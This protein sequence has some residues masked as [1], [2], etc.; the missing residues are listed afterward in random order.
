MAPYNNAMKTD[1]SQCH[2]PCMCKASAIETRRLSQRYA[3]LKGH[4]RREASWPV[5]GRE[6]TSRRS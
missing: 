3:A 6:R 1:V 5:S 4:Q 2:W